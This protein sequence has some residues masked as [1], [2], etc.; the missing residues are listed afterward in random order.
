MLLQEWAL[1]C[2]MAAPSHPPEACIFLLLLLH[3]SQ[4][5]MLLHLLVPHMEGAR[6]DHALSTETP[7][8]PKSQW[9]GLGIPR[10]C[11]VGKQGEGLW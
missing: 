11:P 7:S 10:L 2:G 9:W 5:I 4:G 3:P 8:K 6:L 1:C